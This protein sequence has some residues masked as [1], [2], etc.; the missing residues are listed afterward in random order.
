MRH[1]M[2]EDMADHLITIC[3]KQLSIIIFLSYFHTPDYI[4]P[5]DNKCLF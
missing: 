1:E 4:K 2:M 5:S 3:K